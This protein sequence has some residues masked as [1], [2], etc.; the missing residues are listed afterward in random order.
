[1]APHSP[2]WSCMVPYGPLWSLMVMYGPI[3]SSIVQYGLND[4]KP[5]QNVS[6]YFHI[7]YYELFAF[8]IKVSKKESNETFFEMFN[9]YKIFQYVA[10]VQ[11]TQLL[12]KFCA[13]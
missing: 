9:Y 2:L 6:R 13:C 4:Y 5:V 10:F 1:M 8:K 11:L 12:H 7:Q 3:W